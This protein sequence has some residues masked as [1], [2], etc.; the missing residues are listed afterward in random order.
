MLNFNQESTWTVMVMQNKSKDN[1]RQTTSN[2]A[3][4][5]KIFG[6]KEMKV[7]YDFERFY[8]FSCD[9]ER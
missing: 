3:K 9:D 6:Q 1:Q 5:G 8:C 2:C 7:S 4:C